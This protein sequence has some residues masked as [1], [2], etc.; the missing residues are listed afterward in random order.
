M[1]HFTPFILKKVSLIFSLLL[2]A[3]ISY[4]AVFTATASG[5]FSSSAT[6]VGGIV[7]PTTLTTD[8]IIIPLGITVNLDE[9]LTISGPAA[10][11]NVNGSLMTNDSSSLVMV[12]GTL[13]GTGTIALNTIDLKA[14]TTFSFAGTI[15]VKELNVDATLI[16][17]ADMTVDKTLGLQ[18]GDLALTSGGSVSLSPD[19]TIVISGGTMT[20]GVGGS[21]DL[22]TDYSVVYD[23]ASFTAGI[24]LTGSGLKDLEMSLDPGSTLTLSSDVTLDGKLALNGGTLSLANNDLVINGDIS[25]STSGKIFSTSLSDITLNALSSTTGSLTFEAYSELKDLI[26]NLPPDYAA[27]IEGFLTLHGN[28]ILDSGILQMDNADVEIRGDIS[29]SGIVIGHHITTGDIMVKLD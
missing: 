13:N 4:G 17:N 26:I 23:G 5:N 11:L 29:G 28:L 14:G 15:L 8:V 2:L 25:S 1:K 18:S 3:G 27:K 6:W 7:P 24:E 12:Q 22:S 9:D 16:S 19:A 20:V 21:A 10:Q